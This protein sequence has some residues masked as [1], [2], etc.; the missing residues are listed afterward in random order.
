MREGYALSGRYKIVRS[1]GEGG[2]ANVYLAHDLILN[3]DVAVKL[4]RLDLRDDQ[5]AIRRF[6]RE[7]NSLTELVNP[8]IVNIYDVDEDNGMQY[9]VMEYVDGT[10]LK[11]YIARNHPMPYARIIEIFLQILS[12]VDEAHA[13]GIIHRDLKPQNILMDKN[14]NVKVTDFGIAVAA[15]EETMTR[16]YTLMG[17]V[18]YISPE[19]ARGSIITKQSDIYS[20]GIVLFEMLTGHVPYEGETAVSIALKHY[21]NEMPSVRKYDKKIPQA[22]ENVVLHA[23]AK[24]LNDRYQNVAEMERDLRTS[25]SSN[26]IN[27]PKWHPA[28]VVDGETKVLPTL[29]KS[30]TEQEESDQVKELEAEASEV[31]GTFVKPKWWSFLL[32]GRRK[33]FLFS[34]ILILF[35]SVFCLMLRPKDVAVPDLRG[36]TRS[37]ASRMLKDEKLSLGKVSYRYSEKFSYNQIIT[38]NPEYGTKVKEN[39]A[40]NVVVSKGLEKVKFGNYRGRSYNS[41]KKFLQKRGVTVYKETKY[42]NKYA[43]G[44]IIDQSIPPKEKIVLSQATVS[45]TVSLGAKNIM[46]RDLRGYSLKE[47]QDYAEE[48]SLNLIIKR[49]DS[50][51]PVNTVVAQYPVANTYVGRGSSLTVSISTG[52]K[53]ESSASS[54]SSSFSSSSSSSSSNEKEDGGLNFTKSISIPYKGEDGHPVTVSIYVADKN[55]NFNKA[56]KTMPISADASETVNFSVDSGQVGKYKVVAADGTVLV[57]DDNVTP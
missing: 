30:V 1:L 53:E 34:T 11:E 49:I 12:A 31:L 42:S 57:E 50:D 45:F 21:Q 40:V 22:L 27:E 35:M 37:E 32:K 46:V 6:R 5:A 28:I 20:L 23:T 17:S 54:S 39:T 24:N 26:R 52:K 55:H 2:M 14:G 29:D 43:K 10:D 13:H 47:V 7:A 15:A 44:E 25:L 33:W 51:E 56:Y 3:R 41:V 18:H 16:T 8:Y 19:Q 9:L 4:L 48:S 36:M 38:S